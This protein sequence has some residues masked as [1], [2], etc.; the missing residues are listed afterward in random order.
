M[1]AHLLSSLWAFTL[2]TSALWI[3]PDLVARRVSTVSNLF[4]ARRTVNLARAAPPKI[5]A[6]F[7][8]DFPQTPNGD[9]EKTLLADAF[10][11]IYTLVWVALN[12]FDATVFNR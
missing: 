7:M 11:D 4:P 3:R 2:S 10:P 12:K 1:R 9:D 8:G 5:P 6:F